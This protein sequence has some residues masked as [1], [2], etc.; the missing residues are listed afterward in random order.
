MYDGDFMWNGSVVFGDGW[1]AYQG[2]TDQN[3]THAHAAGQLAFA[4]GGQMAIVGEDGAVTGAALFI[5]PGVRHSAPHTSS[6]VLFLYLAPHSPLSRVLMQR[7]GAQGIAAIDALLPARASGAIDAAAVI[8]ALNRQFCIAPVALDRR[9]QVAIDFLQ[10]R[11]GQPGAIAQAARQAAL[12]ESRLRALA[13]EGLGVPLSQW[14]LWTKLETAATAIAAGA[15]LA[16]AAADGGFADQAH[17]SRTMRRMFGVTPSDTID[18]LQA[19]KRFV[20]DR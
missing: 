7:Y 8:D 3:S 6:P 14:L 17:L 16:V 15:P 4:I 9:L 1:V 13:T 2:E 10:P 11:S 18:P 20:Q 12:S 5:A 19:R